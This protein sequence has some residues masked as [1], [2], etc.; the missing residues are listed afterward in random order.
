MSGGVD[1]TYA[2]RL[3]I[4]A[5]HTVEGAVLVMHEYTEVEDAT[6]AART[7]GIP[8]TVVDCRD[9]FDKYVKSNLVNE[10]KN[11][12]T[13][14]P[15]IV[16]NENVKFKRLY[17]LT[18]ERGFDAIA[19]GHYARIESITEGAKS[20]YVIASARD[21]KK[22][23]AYMLYRLPQ[24]ILAKLLLP[25][26]ELLKA[27]VKQDA[28]ENELIAPDKKESQEICFLPDGHHAEYIE[29]VIGKSPEGYFI[30]ESGNNI[31]MHKGILRY[32]VGQRKGLGISMG[33]RVFVTEINPVDNTVKLSDSPAKTDI[34]EIE[35]IIPQD[36]VQTEWNSEE[37]T[38]KLRYQAPKVPCTVEILGSNRARIRLNASARSVAKGQSAVV[39]DSRGRV[40]LGGF[41]SDT[42]R[43]K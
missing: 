39:F 18:L 33:K 34:V 16:C 19:T 26:G 11:G 21:G 7:L 8:I 14:N 25:L 29:S 6:K 35:A 15:C 9:D 13:P 2:A 37:L 5:G 20:R 30:D 23:Q 22:D 43:L 31:G 24:S 27:D 17:D 40:V 41:I 42:S 10:Y 3:L 36:P 38:V 4:D 28:E 12:R 1:S 32:T